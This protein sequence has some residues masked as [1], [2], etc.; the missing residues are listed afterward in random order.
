MIAYSCLIILMFSNFSATADSLVCCYFIAFS[1]IPESP[2]WLLQI[3]K[4][5]EGQEALRKI[6]AVNKF[7]IT[8]RK[9]STF[10]VSSYLVD[11]K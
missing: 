3:G 2:T 1:L 6:V 10:S 8:R 4:V 11:E 5:K 7:D 9:R